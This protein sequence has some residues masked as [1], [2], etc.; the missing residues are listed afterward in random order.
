MA[1]KHVERTFSAVNTMKVPEAVCGADDIRNSKSGYSMIGADDIP[2]SGYG[3][4]PLCE[5]PYEIP[6]QFCRFPR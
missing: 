5:M 2:V 4:P 1:D 6:V 3:L